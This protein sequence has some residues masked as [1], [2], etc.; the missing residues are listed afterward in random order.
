MYNVF[1]GFKQE[2]TML[3]FYQNPEIGHEYPKST[4]HNPNE[5]LNDYFVLQKDVNRD[6]KGP[7]W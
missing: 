3:N 5:K 7:T 4:E 2:R 1:D 6:D